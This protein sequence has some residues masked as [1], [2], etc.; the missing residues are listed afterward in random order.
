[1]KN[2]VCFRFKAF[3]I[4]VEI[5][6]F[7]AYVFV[8]GGVSDSSTLE[9]MFQALIQYI[10]GMKFSIGDQTGKFCLIA[11]H[12]SSGNSYAVKT[13]VSFELRQRYA[14]CFFRFF[15]F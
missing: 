15:Y 10:L 13:C 8:G 7:I 2:Q 5:C 9:C 14:T 11:L 1:M 4:L 12:E 3:T 6:I